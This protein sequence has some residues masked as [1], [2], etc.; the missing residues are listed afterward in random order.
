VLNR[1]WIVW[2][3]GMDVLKQPGLCPREALGVVTDLA[4]AAFAAAGGAAAGAPDVDDLEQ[5]VD[6]LHVLRSDNADFAFF[7]G[8]LQMLRR[9]WD[10][11]EWIFR[12]LV[13]RSVCVPASHGMLLQCLKARNVF[14]WQDEARR[15]ADEQGDSD[16]G[17]L[18]RT[19]LA[20]A[21]LQRATLE[22]ARTGRFVPPESALALERDDDA[23]AAS[24]AGF[25]PAPPELP[26]T[27]QYLRV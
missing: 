2:E 14:G 27:L 7:D 5:L 11:A 15:I 23:P 20:A 12:G 18:A 24:G 8:W 16:V 13:A 21:D 17:R 9:N 6:A 3:K 25:A 26:L 10:E 22:A 1:I 4:A 19:L